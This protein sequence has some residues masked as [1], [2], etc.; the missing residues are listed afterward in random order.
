MVHARAMMKLTDFDL[1]EVV[2]EDGRRLGRVFDLRIHGRPTTR[3]TQQRADVDQLVYGTLG[4]LERLG[5]RKATGRTL[6]WDQVVSVR[7]GSLVIKAAPGATQ[8]NSA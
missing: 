4:L 5:L 3:S 1:L 7:A 6:R 8:A 2:T